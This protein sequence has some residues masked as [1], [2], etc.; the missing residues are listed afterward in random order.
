MKPV[1]KKKILEHGTLC[2]PLKKDK[3]DNRFLIENKQKQYLSV[4]GKKGLLR[5]PQQ[6]KVSFRKKD[7]IKTFTG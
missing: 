2:T 3:I 4:K 1:V 7:T 6:M 5:I